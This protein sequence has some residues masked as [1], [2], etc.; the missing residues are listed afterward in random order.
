MHA[1][2]KQH[3]PNWQK[4]VDTFT[5]DEQ[6]INTFFLR[7]AS[8][9]HEDIRLYASNRINVYLGILLLGNKEVDESANSTIVNVFTTNEQN[10][11]KIHG[12]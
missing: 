6:F 4:F 11:K 12:A 2:V 8:I 9:E 10:D 7:L 3:I 1:Y 5:P